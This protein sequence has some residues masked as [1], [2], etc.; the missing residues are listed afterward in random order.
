MEM[1]QYIVL[2]L[3]LIGVIGARSANMTPIAITGFN[4]DV[5]VENTSSGPPYTTALNFNQGENS[6]F[7]Q[8]GL[9]GKSYGLPA[10]G[11]FTSALGDGTV[12]QFQNY[13]ASNALVLSGDTGITNG[14]LTLVTPA[15]YSRICV[16]ANSGNGTSGNG[17]L[18]APVQRQQPACH[19]LLRTGLVQ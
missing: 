6:T 14:T 16:I 19:E 7:Y 10:S 17:T 1:R 9:S 11:T 15:T 5:V 3:A 4:R 18:S 8:N 13:A 2:V 12:F